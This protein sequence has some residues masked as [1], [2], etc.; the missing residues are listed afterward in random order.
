MAFSESKFNQIKNLQKY[1][2]NSIGGDFQS[3]IIWIYKDIL[4]NYFQN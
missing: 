2:Q 3:Q 4:I 1:T